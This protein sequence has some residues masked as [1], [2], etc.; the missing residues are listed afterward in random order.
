[1]PLAPALNLVC[2][3]GRPKPTF[4][5]SSAMTQSP[6]C[7]SHATCAVIEFFAGLLEDGVA[8]SG[9]LPTDNRDVDVA[10]IQLDADSGAARLFGGNKR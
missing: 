1:L 5:S 4:A 3:G 6:Q 8:A 7:R 10:R 9:V 2:L